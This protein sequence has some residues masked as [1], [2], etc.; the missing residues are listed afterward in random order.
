[1]SKP[2]KPGPGPSGQLF[3]LNVTRK[4][5]VDSLSSTGTCVAN[6]THL[7]H[8]K[9][10]YWNCK[11]A[12]FKCMAELIH[13]VESGSEFKPELAVVDDEKAS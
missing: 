12:D 7:I 8:S 11:I 3:L 5:V 10:L 6:K 1:M 4:R 13:L 9:I 2:T